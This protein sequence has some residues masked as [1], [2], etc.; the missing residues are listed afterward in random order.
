M[1]L[2]PEAFESPPKSR[3]NASLHSSHKTLHYGTAQELLI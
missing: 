1:K 3:Y 2:I